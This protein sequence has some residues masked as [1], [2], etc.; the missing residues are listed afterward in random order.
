MN[1]MSFKRGIS[2]LKIVTHNNG[3]IEVRVCPK[4]NSTTEVT[5]ECLDSNILEILPNPRSI[6]NDKYRIRLF[7]NDSSFTF[8]Y[9]FF[10]FIL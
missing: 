8:K 6:A 9:I 4:F 3:T 7:S 5:Q 10:K 1:F 2:I